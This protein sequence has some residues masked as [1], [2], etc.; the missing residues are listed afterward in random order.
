MQVLWSRLLLESPRLN[1]FDGRVLKLANQHQQ[2]QIEIVGL[3]K[4]RMQHLVCFRDGTLVVHL[5]SVQD[6][7]DFD[8]KLSSIEHGL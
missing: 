8:P 3:L 4:R 6:V 7:E 2:Q 5:K 1:A